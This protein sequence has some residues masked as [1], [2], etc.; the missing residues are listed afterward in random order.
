A[1]EAQRSARLGRAIERLPVRY[2]LPLVL[3]YFADENYA[4]IAAAL[5]VSRNQ[6][7]SLLFRAKRMLRTSLAD[8]AAGGGGSDEEGAP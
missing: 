3:R 6:V 4:G 7:G 8:D 2:R 1:M 5:G